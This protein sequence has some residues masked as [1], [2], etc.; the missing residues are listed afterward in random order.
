VHFFFPYPEHPAA[1]GAK[2][3]LRK[4]DIFLLSDYYKAKQTLGNSVQ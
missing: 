1:A 2:E 3:L 4:E